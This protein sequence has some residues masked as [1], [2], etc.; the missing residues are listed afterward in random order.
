M[1][2]CARQALYQTSHIPRL[3]SLRESEKEK[4]LNPSA[5]EETRLGRIRESTAAREPPGDTH[6]SKNCNSEEQSEISQVQIPT[7][8]KS[9]G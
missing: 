6:E 7:I 2:E 1:L 5:S 8:T 9:L 3:R 4:H